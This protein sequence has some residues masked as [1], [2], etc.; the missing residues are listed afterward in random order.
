M[1]IETGYKTGL[2]G[3]IVEMHARYYSNNS[4]FGRYFEAKVAEGLADFIPRLD[5]SCNQIWHISQSGKI[6]AS[7]A[8]DGEDLGNTTA[9]LRW[10]I[11]DDDLRGTGAGNQLI[12][13]AIDFC[14]TCNF[15]KCVLWTFK[16]LD[17]AKRLYEKNGFVLTKEWEGDQWGKLVTEQKFERA[18]VS[19]RG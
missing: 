5:N 10:F 8:I 15:D 7:I 14:D 3:A 11:V 17:A 4:G 2:I 6:S 12:R 1:K 13:E 9:H 18:R 19:Q 16:G